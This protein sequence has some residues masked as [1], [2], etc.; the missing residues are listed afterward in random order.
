MHAERA[1][2]TN[3]PK[4]PS[5]GLPQFLPRPTG[6]RR[7][8]L[9]RFTMPKVKKIQWSEITAAELQRCYLQLNPLATDVTA[10]VGHDN[11]VRLLRGTLRAWGTPGAFAR[12]QKRE[13][14][15]GGT[16]FDRCWNPPRSPNCTCSSQLSHAFQFSFHSMLPPG[17]Q[18]V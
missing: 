5:R 9:Y 3:P 1:R 11:W 7:L 4:P 8:I 13:K 10:I 17:T 12:A 16:G 15:R 18:S 6:L 2:C 14:S